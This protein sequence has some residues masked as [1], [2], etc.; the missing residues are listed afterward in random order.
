[1]KVKFTKPL[2]ARRTSSDPLRYQQGL[3]NSRKEVRN[4]APE[5]VR[6]DAGLLHEL[7][8]TARVKDCLTTGVLSFAEGMAR[9][10]KIVQRDIMASFEKVITVGLSKGKIYFAWVRHTE[11]RRVELHFTIFRELIGDGRRVT[12]YL[13]KLDHVLLTR[14]QWLINLKYELLGPEAAPK[15]RLVKPC[16]GYP[17][18]TAQKMNA[19]LQQQFE[20]HGVFSRLEAW[21]ALVGAGFVFW[22]HADGGRSMGAETEDGKSVRVAGPVFQPSFDL[23]RYLMTEELRVGCIAKS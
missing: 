8:T 16:L 1:M 2:R 15:A 23:Q 20:E 4:P 7:V 5:V 10:S 21:G 18:E 13:K 9:L 22:R 19:L 11:H 14:W 17:P 3:R 6:G 12:P